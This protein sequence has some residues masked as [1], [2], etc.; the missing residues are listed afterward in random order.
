MSFWDDSGIFC[1]N[2]DG[3]RSNPSFSRE[4]SPIY[5]NFAIKSA[6]FSPIIYFGTKSS[7]SEYEFLHIILL[8]LH[9]LGNLSY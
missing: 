7:S 3:F 6:Y 4:K 8:K 9:Y 1:K 5:V 2:S